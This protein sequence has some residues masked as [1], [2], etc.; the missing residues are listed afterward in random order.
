[1]KLTEAFTS[2]WQFFQ[3]GGIFMF[4]LALCSLVAVTVIILKMIT[5][6]RKNI[7]PDRLELE[8]EKFEE[9]LEA[10][11]LTELQAEF[12]RGENSL[13]RLCA[14]ALRNAGRTQGEVQEAVQSSAREE[15]VRMNSGLPVLEVIITISPLLGLL[16]TASG[17]VSVF[18]DLDANAQIQK[19]IAT[20]LSTT[21]VGLAVAIPSVIA[22]SVFSRKIETFSARLEVLLGRVVSACHQHVFFRD[23]Q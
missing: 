15:I 11:T 13:A 5:L 22:Q 8:V 9:H 2:T 1:M 18:E 17:L 16:G 21:I 20:A 10:G 14:V 4:F 19:G 7:L 12:L 6:T 23:N 3:G